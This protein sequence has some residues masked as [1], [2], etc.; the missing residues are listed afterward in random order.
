MRHRVEGRK[1]GRPSGHRLAMMRNLMVSLIRHE[2]IKTTLA[3]AK[4][5]RKVAEKM[6]TLAKRGDL[7]ARRQ[8]AQFLNSKAETKKLFEELAQRFK[9]RNGG[10]TRIMRLGWRPGDGAPISLIEF[11]PEVREEK[12]KRKTPG[13]KASK[14]VAEK[15]KMKEKESSIEAEQ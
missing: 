11:L 3:R 6:I 4:E 15:K 7:S 13:K 14:E 1:L 10:Y 8:A 9:K 2:R 5:L 12:K